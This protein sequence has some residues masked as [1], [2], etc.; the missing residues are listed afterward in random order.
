MTLESGLGEWL[1]GCI[2]FADAPFDYL[3]ILCTN[4]FGKIIP[5]ALQISKQMIIDVR[6]AIEL[7]DSS[8][9][10]K[11]KPP[12]PIDVTVQML[13]C[14]HEKYDLLVKGN[15]EYF[16]VEL[17]NIQTNIEEMLRMLTKIAR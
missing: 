1:I 15:V 3:V 2:S 16:S 5:S 17:Q 11:L 10:G 12:Y 14:F 6:N 4:D 8:L 13:G 7:E 9:L